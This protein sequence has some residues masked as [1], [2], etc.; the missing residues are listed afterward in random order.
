MS[1]CNFSSLNNNVF[2]VPEVQYFVFLNS[3]AISEEGIFGFFVYS[4]NA[5]FGFHYNG[6]LDFENESK[7]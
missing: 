6:V 3:R 5:I 1:T 2:C 7:P 4:I